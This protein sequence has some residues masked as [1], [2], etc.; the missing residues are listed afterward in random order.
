MLARLVF[1]LLSV[2]ALGATADTDKP[3]REFSR[4]AATPYPAQ[5]ANPRNSDAVSFTSPTELKLKWK[6]LE[7]SS[8]VQG[9]TTD[10][11]QLYCAL[12]WDKT[13]DK[14]NLIT[15]S[16]VDGRVLWEDRINGECVLDEYASLTNPTIDSD[17][18]LYINDSEKI[19]SFTS[20]GQLRWVNKTP[21]TLKSRKGL[22]NAPFGLI[23]LANGELATATMGDGWILFLDSQSGQLT[24]EPFDLP[25]EKRNPHKT[26]RSLLP[27]SRPEG[28]MENLMSP[29]AA[30][31][32]WDFAFGESDYE[33][34]NNIAVAEKHQLLFISSGA[35]YPN[36]GNKGALWAVSFAKG[37]PEV[38]FYVEL[39]VEGGIATS[40]TISKDNRLALIGD[41][42]QNLVTVNI[43]RCLREADGG[44]CEHFEKHP[45]GHDLTSSVIITDNN[46]L[47]I[48]AGQTGYA[49]YDLN[50]DADGVVSLEQIWET[51]L[52][53]FPIGVSVHLAFENVVWIPFY[54]IGRQQ[55][56]I[57]ALDIETG[58]EVAR[59]ESGD[60]ANVTMASDG[61]TIVA[62]NMSFIES[63]FLG[64]LG[65]EVKGGVWAWEPV[66]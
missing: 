50:T 34:D 12:G 54:H 8:I 2:S 23:L 9:C 3:D 26:T 48:P 17:G 51:R 55:P 20:D 14:C 44:S 64:R 40:P 47:I 60:A 57:V 15:L 29:S 32:L 66:D 22:S 36:K 52:A 33:N 58:E 35:P 11:G 49:G 10:R 43:E 46:R 39:D 4:L 28:F 31:M 16:E 41:N 5:H 45:L 19:V 53:W 65:F 62:Q 56:F 37:T 18:N 61:K 27:D 38:A 25:A 1:V 59:Y 30:Q 24:R 6:A 63:A 21:A 7:D 42:E 13:T